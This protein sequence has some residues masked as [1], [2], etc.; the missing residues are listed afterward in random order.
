MKGTLSQA[1]AR[2]PPDSPE[3][4]FAT[5]L[6]S[7]AVTAE[8]HQEWERAQSLYARAL[9]KC[10]LE[11]P[12]LKGH[13]LDDLVAGAVAEDNDNP[14]FG[15][16]EVDGLI[17][18]LSARAGD[19]AG[20]SATPVFPQN[21]RQDRE[22]A[23]SWHDLKGLPW[24]KQIKELVG[25][26][27]WTE[28]EPDYDT[29]DLLLGRRLFVL[30][31][32]YGTLVKCLQK[33]R[34]WAPC[35]VDFVEGGKKTV[36]LRLKG[37]EMGTPFLIS[38]VIEAPVEEESVNELFGD[39]EVEGVVDRAAETPA[40]V[41]NP[42]QDALDLEKWSSLRTL[43][44]GAQLRALNAEGWEEAAVD[45]DQVDSQLFR[46]VYVLEQGFGTLVKV[47]R[48]K[49]G[50]GP[51][52]IDFLE[53]GKKTII[54]RLKGKE[55]G[56]PFMIL[57]KGQ[58]LLGD[59][60]SPRA[61]DAMF[62]SVDDDTV[63]ASNPLFGDEEAH[64]VVD[65]VHASTPRSLY[66]EPDP[67][68]D[69]VDLKVWGVLKARP[70][71]NQLA[72][73]CSKGWTEPAPDCA[74][75][76][77]QIGKRVYVM[78]QGFGIVVK[79]DKTKRGYKPTA[80]QFTD[81][82]KQS[83]VLRAQGKEMG[84][85]FLL[86]PVDE[87]IEAYGDIVDAFSTPTKKP[88]TVQTVEPP[89]TPEQDQADRQQWSSLQ[90][91]R[92]G[93]Q[94]SALAADGW[95]EPS[96]DY[97]I[98]DKHLGQRLFVMEQGFGKL[99]KVE[100]KK[101]GWGP[102]KVD[103]VEGGV[104][105]VVLRLV[106]KEMGTPFLVHKAARSRPMVVPSPA[107][108]F[109]GAGAVATPPA[110]AKKVAKVLKLR[111]V[112]LLP[113]MPKS[114]GR[115]LAMQAGKQAAEALSSKDYATAI[116]FL[117][118][119]IAYCENRPQPGAA[120]LKL[121]A[122]KPSRP[123]PLPPTLTGAAG[124]EPE[125]PSWPEKRGEFIYEEESYNPLHGDDD[126]HGVVDRQKV[127]VAADSEA[128]TPGRHDNEL[129]GDEE[130]HGV[131]DRVHASTPRS[132]YLEPDP[133][134]DA[135][136]LKVWGVLKARP[137]GNQLATLCSKGWTEPAPDCA[138]LEEQIG[139]RV[140]VME[141]GFGIVVK[142]DKTKRGYKPTAIQFTDG[143][144]QSMVLRAQGKEMGTPFLLGPVDES[145][146]AYG[147][148]V[149]A[150]STPTKKPS[151]VQTVEPPATPEQDQADRQQ[152]SSLQSLRW[153]QQISALA[154][155]GWVEPSPDYSIIDKHLGQRLFVMEQG[156]GKLV[157]VE[158]KKR[159]WGPCKVD[160][161]EGGVKLVV[162][163]LVGKEMGT[164]FLIEPE[165]QQPISTLSLSPNVV[166][167]GI[168]PAAAA[169]DIA[170]DMALRQRAEVCSLSFA[171]FPTSSRRWCSVLTRETLCVRAFS[172]PR[173]GLSR[174][175]TSCKLRG[176]RFFRRRRSR[177]PSRRRPQAS[178]AQQRRQCDRLSRMSQRCTL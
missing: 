168:P 105:L 155:D 146:E 154:A 24:G 45:Y 132:L 116:T 44:W 95:V 38:P 65:R 81:G 89:A 63:Q 32:G 117:E 118:S 165:G 62:L 57:K 122:T 161:V 3:K 49:R 159:G 5:H 31:H 4:K 130:A 106:G 25:G 69:A 110:D 15:D 84:T 74:D 153:G 139:K 160:F 94:I 142:V 20:P 56:T 163:R 178:S 82:G 27:G 145:I 140:Y 34:G 14:L 103:F 108:S 61:G 124:A 2:L 41:S 152:W 29:M 43:G 60:G 86:G 149:D 55:M 40:R 7:Q 28:P 158:Q 112:E 46:R 137:W 48:R 131:V 104:K 26:N 70:W 73:L 167:E 92:W 23:Q 133:E 96:P 166:A 68:R 87:S 9:Q 17:E 93:Q 54:L 109:T 151:T 144:K 21:D 1:V 121:V 102:C 8:Q 79:V 157:K 170:A 99:V 147:D 97:S 78:E 173:L 67:E 75:L 127:A 169:G 13:D 72:T 136:D 39:D 42:A 128:T 100:Q 125:S 115:I 156:F 19:R 22:D 162:L 88:S 11:T 51:S 101:R 120:E 123:A 58:H 33:K 150:F 16:D 64:G 91:L 66:L 18:R 83:M 12:E 10:G 37:K 164:P 135:V 71:G 174:L 53:G 134:R 47:Q 171:L 172:S 50:W 175:S 113:Q 30:E 114:S 143:G 85:P 177:H 141:Q 176:R 52:S 111:F 98:I 59:P 77:E 35:A 138:D 126:V 107:G 6:A 129:F 36:I 76:E 148:I 80:I 90:S 119:A